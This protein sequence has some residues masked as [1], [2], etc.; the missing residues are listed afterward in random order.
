MYAN[1]F[2]PLPNR[3]TRVTS[4]SAT[5]IDHLNSN[6]SNAMFQ[7]ILV[8]D[9]TDHYPIFQMCRLFNSTRLI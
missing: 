6:N 2:I 5:I 1:I 4:Q 9:V 8:T 7:G 3:P